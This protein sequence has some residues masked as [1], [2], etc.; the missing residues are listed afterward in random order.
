MTQTYLHDCLVQFPE[1]SAQQFGRAPDLCAI[2][3]ES[4]TNTIFARA[5]LRLLERN[6]TGKSVDWRHLRP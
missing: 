3:H 4:E 5:K 6:E 1:I 2:E